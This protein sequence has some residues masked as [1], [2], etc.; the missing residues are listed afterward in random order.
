MM[1]VTEETDPKSI[2]K[3]LVCGTCVNTHEDENLPASRRICLEGY[4]IRGVLQ[5]ACSLWSG[6]E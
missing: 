1:I 5:K 2:D 6:K 4:G 3:Q